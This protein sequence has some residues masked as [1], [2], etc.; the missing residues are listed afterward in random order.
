MK[1][2]KFMK[3]LMGGKRD[4]NSSTA[5]RKAPA[6]FTPICVWVPAGNLQDAETCCCGGG[7]KSCDMPDDSGDA[8][9]SFVRIDWEELST[10][11][12]STPLAVAYWNTW[13]KRQ[14]EEDS[15]AP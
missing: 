10:P 3:R 13:G 8:G 14:D 11:A 7:G 9:V 6:T 4:D 5:S 2:L 1:V 12:P 15:H